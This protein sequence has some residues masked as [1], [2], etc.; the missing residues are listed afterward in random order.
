[1]REN[2]ERGFFWIVLFEQ[3]ERT[4]DEAR[5]ASRTPRAVGIESHCENSFLVF[6]I[7]QKPGFREARNLI[8]FLD[9]CEPM[10]SSHRTD[11]R[12]RALNR[13]AQ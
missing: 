10:P 6:E 7:R 8:S 2:G 12:I 4:R 1:M 5:P 9:L 11:A 13:Q 3:I